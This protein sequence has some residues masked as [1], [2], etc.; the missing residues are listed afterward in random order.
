VSSSLHESRYQRLRSLLRAARRN[1]GLTQAQLARR[2][3]LGQSFV[4]KVE[5]GQSYV[6]VVL[7]VDWCD[8]CGTSAA[9]IVNALKNEKNDRWPTTA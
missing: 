8:A 4:S 6:D 9:D 1:A 2:L 3:Q 5:R 7:L